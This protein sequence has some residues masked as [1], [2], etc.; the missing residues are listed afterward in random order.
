M[1]FCKMC[2]KYFEQTPTEHSNG[3]GCSMGC[4]YKRTFETK[5][6][7]VKDEFDE[8]VR[9]T[10]PE[11]EI[12]KG[13]CGIDH[14]MEFNCKIHGKFKR[15]ARDMFKNQKRYGKSEC[16]VKC[17]WDRIGN[18]RRYDTKKFIETL[19]LKCPEMFDTSKVNYKGQYIPIELIC[20]KSNKLFSVRPSNVL[21]RKTCYCDDCLDGDSKGEERISEI[22]N[23]FN[24]KYIKHHGFDNCRSRNKLTFDFYLIDY[25]ILIEFDGGQHFMPIEFFGGIESL[26]KSLDRDMIKDNFC[27]QNEI[28]LLRIPYWDFDDLDIILTEILIDFL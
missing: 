14:Y 9:T 28:N 6:N 23:Y 26:M 25:N 10:F 24:I 12:I 15:K 4:Q 2:N 18:E 21:S 1:I 27:L 20:K 17:S 16:C 3:S 19:E 5:I 11:I 22:L 8:R 13:Y 7:N